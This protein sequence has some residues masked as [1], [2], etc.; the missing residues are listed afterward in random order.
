MDVSAPFLTF[1]DYEPDHN[2][3][4]SLQATQQ[5]FERQT[6]IDEW[7]AGRGHVDIVLD[8]LE[9][10]GVGADAF[11]SQV[12]DQ[13]HYAIEGRIY[14]ENPTGLLLPKY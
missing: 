8:C 3:L 4:D 13:V 11:V 7:L 14:V 10:Q 9:E 1:L 6:I 12:C 2:R 5:L